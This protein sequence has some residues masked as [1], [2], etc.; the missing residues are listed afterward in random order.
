MTLF[1]FHVILLQYIWPVFLTYH[2]SIWLRFSG[3]HVAVSK[4]RKICYKF[5][6]YFL[7]NYFWIND[8]WLPLPNVG[9]YFLMKTDV[10]LHSS[11]FV[12]FPGWRML[13]TCASHELLE[14]VIVA[15]LSSLSGF[16][17]QFTPQ[18]VLH[19]LCFINCLHLC[20][21]PGN[22]WWKLAWVAGL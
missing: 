6:W 10:C 17:F 8:T 1:K 5:W 20:L 14:P 4:E 21:I 19:H 11:T 16:F 22:S 9:P 7:L 2:F 15:I 18:T 3:L 13:K 12:Y